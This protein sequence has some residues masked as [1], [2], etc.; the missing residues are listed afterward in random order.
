MKT[1][2][3]RV[4][5]P[6]GD[7]LA[8]ERSGLVVA[9]TWADRIE[10]TE[11]HL[12]RHLP[13]W[14]GS[15]PASTTTCG[16]AL[17]AYFEGDMNALSTVAVDPPGTAFQQRV[18]AALQTIPAGIAWSYKELAEAIG[19]PTAQR[20]VAAANGRNPIPIIIPCHRVI[21]ASGHLGG[22][23]AGLQRKRH[24]LD[25]EGIRFRD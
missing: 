19:R 5:S 8:Y 9:L 17:V 7:L 11:A 1:S 12:N 3:C 23:S 14:T 16:E 13:D 25:H 4:W 22:F 21:A 24:L 18:W 2:R 15:T 6:L 10:Q 20:A